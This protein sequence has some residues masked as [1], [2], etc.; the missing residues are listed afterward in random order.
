MKKIIFFLVLVI[1]GACS[2]NDLTE[3]ED[4]SSLLKGIQN[5]DTDKLKLLE[6]LPDR[7]KSELL[8]QTTSTEKLE[9]GKLKSSARTAADGGQNFPITDLYISKGS[10]SSIYA[11]YGNSG[12]GFLFDGPSDGITDRKMASRGGLV[13]TVFTSCCAQNLWSINVNTRFYTE[14][15]GASSWYGINALTALG[16]Y[17]Y[18]VQGG[19]FWR[20]N[21][22]GIGSREPFSNYPLNWENTEAM[23]AISN[24]IYTI[25]GGTLWKTTTNGTVSTFSQY[26]TGWGGT[27][28]M[29]ATNGGVFVVQGGTLWR[30]DIN[31]GNVVPYSHY[32]TGWS[33]TTVM[34]A[35]DGF[36]YIIQG[37][38]IWKVSTFNQSVIQLGNLSWTGTNT[39]TAFIP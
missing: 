28:A 3:K 15:Y 35:K 29:A 23:A 1:V 6:N 25:Q 33:G 9:D 14:L 21:P 27:E 10:P 36:L 22:S 8:Q 30:V 2:Q 16:S 39:M 5:D 31:N 32:P 38:V 20:I 11:I 26:P 18:A 12:T 13:Y 17:L 4:K 7:N 19:T 34:T 24:S 37:G